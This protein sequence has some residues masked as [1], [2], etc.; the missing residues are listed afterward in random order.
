MLE[1]FLDLFLEVHL[2][3]DVHDDQQHSNNEI[4]HLEDIEGLEVVELHLFGLMLVEEPDGDRYLVEE[5]EESDNLI[6]VEVVLVA[7]EDLK[8]SADAVGLHLAEDPA[9]LAVH[10]V[11]NP[12]DVVNVLLVLLDLGVVRTEELHGL[13]LAVDQVC[14]VDIAE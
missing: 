12:R 6:A 13:L 4:P 7:E 14:L 10:A 9:L 8:G 3:E 2:T 11:H 1:L 5:V